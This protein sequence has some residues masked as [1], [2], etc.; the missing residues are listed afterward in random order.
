VHQL[1]SKGPAC[2][3]VVVRKQLFTTWPLVSGHYR[4]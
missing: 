1:A 4:H 2:V 3:L